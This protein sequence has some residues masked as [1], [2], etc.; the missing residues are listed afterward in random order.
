VTAIRSFTRNQNK[1]SH[2]YNAFSCLVYIY[3]TLGTL[4]FV[5]DWTANLTVRYAKDV[6]TAILAADII[7]NE[8]GFKD[9]C[10]DIYGALDKAPSYSTNCQEIISVK[11][12]REHVT[13]CGEADAIQVLQQTVS[14]IR[15]HLNARVWKYSFKKV[16][17]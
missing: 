10:L 17:S 13:L 2:S 12:L 5:A 1:D 15:F 11:S 3:N 6:K 7:V 14:L 8:W 16:C 9:Y 4:P